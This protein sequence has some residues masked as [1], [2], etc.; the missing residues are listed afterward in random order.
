MAAERDGTRVTR[1][2]ILR[3]TAC[4]A[5]GALW[6]G[7]LGPEL[8]AGPARP[9][10]ARPAQGTAAAVDPIDAARAQM[11]AAP[12]EMLRLADNLVLLSGPGGNVLVLYGPDG[13]V[14]VDTFVQPAWAGLQTA[15]DGLGASAATLIVNTHWHFDHTDNNARFRRAGAEILAHANTARRLAETHKLL[16]MRFTPVPEEARPTDTFLTT[17]ALQVN[18][19]DVTLEYVSAAHTDSDVSVR[20]AKAQVLHLGDTFFNGSY[21]FIDGGTGGNVN[22]MVAS[23][24]RVLQNADDALRIVPGHGPMGD[25]AALAS[26]REM[27]VTV[28]DRVGKLRQDGKSRE[29][30]VAARPTADLDARWGRGFMQPDDFVAN[31]Y[32]TL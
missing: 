5:A 18:G 25:R 21:P 17:R 24:D 20:C 26:F 28:R 12:I 15:I 4:G 8:W 19:E 23:A 11:A 9:P 10:L 14:V 13:T 7:V 22:G 30:T 6:S 1:R 29:E 27:L 32:D 16:G 3:T 31:V 2:Q